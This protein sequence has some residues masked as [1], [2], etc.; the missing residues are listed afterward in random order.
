MSAYLKY[1]AIKKGE[2]KAKGHEGDKGWIE[3][4]SV[5]L[6]V[7]RSISSPVGAS[8][9]REAS[10]PNV[11]EIVLSKLMDSTSPLI[12]QEAL[13][14]KA[15]SAQVDLV[16]THEEMLETFLE[17][18]LTNAMIAS[19]S[20]SSNGGRPSEKFS[21]NFT[22]IEYKYTPFDDKH[23]RGSPVLFMYDVTTATAT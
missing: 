20:T 22:K 7:G 21:L 12:F 10:A 17:I 13:L 8:S 11:S 2:S 1:E 18:K 5:S 9:K 15:A 3:L 4:G 16:E 23:Q 19:Y 6:G 14:G